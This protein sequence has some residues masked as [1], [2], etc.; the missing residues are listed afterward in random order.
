MRF[1]HSLVAISSAS[2][3]H[4]R[5]AG[6]VKLIL[7]VTLVLTTRGSSLAKTSFLVKPPPL[8]VEPLSPNPNSNALANEAVNGI[9]YVLV[10]Q[11]FR[12]TG[13][14]TQRYYRRVK[15]VL[16][17]AGLE[18][19]SQIQIEFEPSYQELVFHHLRILRGDATIDG[20]N[21]HEIKR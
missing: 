4:H 8:W 1:T 5:V 12:V 2:K 15:R 13:S 17:T 6:L 18:N 14:G 9:L 21:P 7:L 3:Q 20:L 10:D 19:V 16:S 11:Q